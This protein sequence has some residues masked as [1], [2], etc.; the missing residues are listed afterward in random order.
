MI[1]LRRFLGLGILAAFFVLAP[2]VDLGAGSARDVLWQV[3]RSCVANYSLTG[4]AFPC[5]SVDLRGGEANGWVVLRPPLG[6]PDTVLA[7]TVRIVGAEDPRLQAPDAANYFADAWRAHKF[8]E[9]GGVSLA[10]GETAVAVNSKFA[11]TQDQ[12]HL[13]IGCLAPPVRI[14]LE[15]LAPKLSTGVWTRA[16]RL[17][18][19]GRET[20]VLR[21]GSVDLTTLQ[22]FRKVSEI[23]PDEQKMERMLIALTTTPVE[24]RIEFIVIATRIVPELGPRAEDVVTP[25]CAVRPRQEGHATEHVTGGG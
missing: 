9:G 17:M 24:G 7:P 6:E 8:V 16:D 25:R 20:W 2:S 3:V 13:H 18:P 1:T 15:Q 4:L 19:V 5:L 14:S 21:T 22:P 12:L 23:A 10:A 11:R